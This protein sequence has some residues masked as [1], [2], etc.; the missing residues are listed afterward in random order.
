MSCTRESLLTNVTLCPAVIVTDDGV[1]APFEPMV[2]VAPTGPGLP[3]TGAVGDD[4]DDG[5]DGELLPPHA[6]ATTS[7]AIAI[8]SAIAIRFPS[9]TRASN[10]I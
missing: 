8:P 10:L 5:D 6:A 9:V 1:A 3:V 4:G 2:M 7:A